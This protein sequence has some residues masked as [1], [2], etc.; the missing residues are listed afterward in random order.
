MTTAREAFALYQAGRMAEAAALC[1][2]LVAESPSV[3][4]WHLLGVA[5]LALSQP[6]EALTALDAGLALDTERSGLLSARTLALTALARDEAAVIAARTALAADPQN[7]P[8]FN[9]LGVSLRRLGRPSEA[10]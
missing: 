3:E 6:Q 9:A 1:E 10:L 4:A 2:R 5:R 7:P 8:V